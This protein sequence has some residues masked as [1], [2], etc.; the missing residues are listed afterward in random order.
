MPLVDK[1][2]YDKCFNQWKTSHVYTGLLTIETNWFDDEM[3]IPSAQGA[4]TKRSVSVENSIDQIAS[5]QCDDYESEMS[6]LVYH[7]SES[8][9]EENE[10]VEVIRETPTTVSKKR[11]TSKSKTKENSNSDDSGITQ[12]LLRSQN[13][14]RSL[15]SAKQT[16][17]SVHKSIE[18]KSKSDKRSKTKQKRPKGIEKSERSADSCSSITTSTTATSNS[19]KTRKK[20]DTLTWSQES[21]TSDIQ[22]VHEEH[23]T[24]IIIPGSSETLI[25]APDANIAAEIFQGSPDLF[26]SFHDEPA[27]AASST[28][29]S[30]IPAGQ[31]RFASTRNDFDESATVCTQDIFAESQ[32]IAN[33]TNP[34]EALSTTTSDI[35]EITSNNI[36]HNVLKASSFDVTPVTTSGTGTSNKSCFS[37]VRVILPRLKSDDILELQ[38]GVSQRVR[39]QSNTPEGLIDLTAD[40]QVNEA[41]SS[42]SPIVVTDI[43]KTPQRKRPLTPST[44]SCVKR[45][46]D[47]IYISSDEEV[48][49]KTPSRSGWLQK[50]S[51]NVTSPHTTPRSRRNLEKWFPPRTT[52][53]AQSVLQPRN[54]F[55]KNEPNQ[56][57]R[58]RANIRPMQESP[59]IF[60]SDDE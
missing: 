12:R 24:P 3:E 17:N 43:E 1:N 49:S 59:S 37:G 44:R 21:S 46:S 48:P 23:M 29:S 53:K 50:R 30:P 39:E 2:V 51:S 8:D 34:V 13:I 60:S 4:A 10:G 7:S 40:S 11:A 41:I 56:I 25:E 27:E 47:E 28:S 58:L 42:E 6:P 16:P 45:G 9:M 55:Q 35:F 57:E 19:S 31:T 32:D 38:R 36:F 14:K 54:I 26:A 20:G 22:L 52:T 5:N 18:K 15:R 33:T